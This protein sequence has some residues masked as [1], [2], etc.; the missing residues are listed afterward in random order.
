AAAAPAPAA[1]PATLEED[2]QK[3]VDA[4]V[5]EKLQQKKN[6]TPGGED[7]KM[8]LFDLAKELSL[9][10]AAQA[11]VA[12][13][14]NTVKKEIFDIIKTP[15]VDGTNLADELL[16]AFTS[17]ETAAVQKVFGKLF[18]DKIPGTDTPYVTAVARVQEKANQGLKQTMGA[19]AFGKYQGMNLKPENIETGFDPW[20][21]YLQQKGK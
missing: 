11:K 19:D 16:T 8:P 12:V 21:D 1:A 15:R 10:D 7:R 17:G 6:S 4:K 14:A 5:E 3:I 20:L 9:D 13:I 18:T 2:I